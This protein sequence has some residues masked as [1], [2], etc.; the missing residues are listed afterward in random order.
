MSTSV[1][2]RGDQDAVALHD[3]LGWEK[4]GPVHPDAGQPT[5]VRLRD[6]QLDGCRVGAAR[7]QWSRW[8][9]AADEC[10]MAAPGP[11]LSAADNMFSQHEGRVPAIA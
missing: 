5:A 8:T 7:T 9:V 1:L 4:S 10:E 3:V 2:G 11:A 6:G